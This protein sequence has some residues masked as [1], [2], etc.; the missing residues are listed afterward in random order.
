MNKTMKRTSQIALLAGSI[1]AIGMLATALVV[2]RH[3]AELAPLTLV[4]PA[5]EAKP[6]QRSLSISFRAYLVAKRWFDFTVAAMALV[7]LSPLMAAIAVLIKL[8]SPGP[9]FF[10]QERVGS[11]VRG[12]NGKRSW[13]AKAF[14][15]YK[16]RTMTV[17]NDAS[18]HQ[19]FVQAMIKGDNATLEQ[20]NGKIEGADKFKIKNDKRVT[21]IGKFLRK[22]SLDELPQLF[23]VIK[24]EM[25]IVGPRPAIAYEVDV[26]APHH[27]RRLEAQQGITG[28]WQATARSNVDFE[29]MVDL[30]AWYVD[31]QSFWLDL[32]IMVMTPLSVLKGKGAA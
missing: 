21:K 14:N 18:E 30:D 24:G 32:K 2:S 6:K 17:N 20:I 27:F 13:E 10:T 8:D 7:A 23:N 15:V 11:K 31:N 1:T 16:F 4:K 29:T 5:V 19:K 9:V 25:S 22:T 3:P 26:Y 28:W 12:K